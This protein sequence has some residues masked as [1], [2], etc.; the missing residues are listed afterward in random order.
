MVLERDD[1]NH[2][3]DRGRLLTTDFVL[4]IFEG[5]CTDFLVQSSQNPRK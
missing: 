4:V 5:L 1:D 2:D 3:N